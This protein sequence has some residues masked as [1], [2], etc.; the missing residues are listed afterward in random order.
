M[1]RNTWQKLDEKFGRPAWPWTRRPVAASNVWF[2]I[3]T[4]VQVFVLPYRLSKPAYFYV[5]T[6][7]LVLTL[8]WCW[9][10]G[11]RTEY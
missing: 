3:L 6:P 10:L 9:R 5:A 11:R 1:Q 4:L 8:W 7:L 2:T